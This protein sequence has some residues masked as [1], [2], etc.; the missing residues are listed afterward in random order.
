MLSAHRYV[1]HKH[2]CWFSRETVENF[3]NYNKNRVEKMFENAFSSRK[4]IFKRTYKKNIY[5]IFALKWAILYP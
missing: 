4:Y 5:G 1:S 3:K 2:N